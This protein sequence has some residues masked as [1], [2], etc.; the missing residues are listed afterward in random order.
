MTQSTAPTV[1]AFERRDKEMG[2]TVTATSADMI[3]LAAR[4]SRKKLAAYLREVAEADAAR[5]IAR[6]NESAPSA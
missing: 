1:P 6:W 2:F 3:R 4:L 5:V